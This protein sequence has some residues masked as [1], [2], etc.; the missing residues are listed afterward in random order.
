MTAKHGA[1]ILDLSAGLLALGGI[2]SGVVA[3]LHLRAMVAIY[4]VICGV[5]DGDP[6]H[7]AACYISLGLFSLAAACFAAAGA[8][9]RDRA[10]T[11]PLTS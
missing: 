10:P 8:A 9:P 2:A 3:W 5:G 7:C 6:P 1:L 4:G 11:D